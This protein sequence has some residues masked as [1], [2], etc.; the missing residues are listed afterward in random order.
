VS[1]SSGDEVPHIFTRNSR[2]QPGEFLVTTAKGLLQQYLPL[3]DVLPADVPA[4]S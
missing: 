2:L 3:P 1:L 4:L